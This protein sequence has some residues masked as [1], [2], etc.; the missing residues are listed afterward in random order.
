MAAG[1]VISLLA[2]LKALILEAEV[3]IGL[4]LC[5]LFYWKTCRNKQRKLCQYA[6]EPMNWGFARFT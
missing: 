3:L 6:Q 1:P 5:A 4:V 2:I